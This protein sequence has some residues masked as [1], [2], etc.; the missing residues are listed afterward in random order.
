VIT[1]LTAR[2]ATDATTE[3][4][5]DPSARLEAAFR[6]VAERM[7]GLAFVNPALAV[8]AVGFAPWKGYWLGVMLT[9]WSMNLVLAPREPAAWRALAAGEK[10]RYDFPAGSFDFISARDDAIGDHLVCSLFSPVL[11]F[12]D[13]DTARETAVQARAALFDGAHAEPREELPAA[14]A[15]APGMLAEI[16]HTLD[17]P[18]SR[19]DLLHGRFRGGE[20]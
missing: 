3:L 4:L 20:R 1:Q 17:A 2:M 18:V 7:R 19:R 12:A 16:A 11:E 10:R 6:S 5:P 9:P 14:G 8:E 13:H 15:A